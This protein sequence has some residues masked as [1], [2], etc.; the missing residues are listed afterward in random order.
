MI[1][2]YDKIYLEKARTALGRMLDFAVYQLGYSVEEFFDMFISSG[3][4][5]RFENGDIELLVGRS[6]VEIAYIVIDSCI[7]GIEPVMVE[8]TVGRSPEYWAG[9][10][11]AY[12]QWEKGISFSQI[13]K[14]IPIN[15][16]V[17]LYSPYHEMDIRQLV[18]RLDELYARA[19][20]DTKLKQRRKQ[21]GLSQSQLA[22]VSGIPIRTIQQYEQRQ[23]DINK[24]GAISVKSLAKALYCGIED[25]LE[26]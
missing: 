3:L 13:I 22:E 4:A 18:D 9:L 20:T 25:L 15:E 23:K 5:K 17:S 24:A 16:I 7:G 14:A 12:Y 19:N 2:A 8:D 21:V 11:L 1:H 26:L 10:A 6:G